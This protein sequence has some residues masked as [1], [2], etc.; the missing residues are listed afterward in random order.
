[1]IISS[2]EEGGSE[3]DELEDDE[4]LVEVSARYARPCTLR[5][6]YIKS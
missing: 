2:D 4:D 5:L 1:V 3:E 6:I